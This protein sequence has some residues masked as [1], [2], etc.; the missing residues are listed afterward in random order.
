MQA[1]V[2]DLLAVK[3][4]HA[5]LGLDET[6]LPLPANNG[7]RK[8]TGHGKKGEYSVPRGAGLAG[9]YSKETS[10]SHA[11]VGNVPNGV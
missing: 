5:H 7:V 4:P 8:R 1:R 3:H 11:S 2:P 10:K 6:R 9:V